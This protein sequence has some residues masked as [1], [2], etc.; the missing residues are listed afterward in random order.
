MKNHNAAVGVFVTVGLIVF[1]VGIF[2]VG[3]R[4]DA[5]ARHV[6]YYAEFTNLNGLTEGSK[7]RVA[8]MDAGQVIEVG[9][10]DNP[11]HRFRIKLRINE[12]LHG[13]IRTDSLASIATEGVVGGTYVLVLPGKAASNPAPPL[14]TLPTK[15]TADISKALDRAIV[16]LSDA[17]ATIN[18]VRGKVS[19]A[20]T[21]VTSTVGNVNQLVLGLKQGHGPAGM[22][23]QDE[24]LASHIRNTVSNTEKATQDLSHAVSQA[25][26]LVADFKG[27]NLPDKVDESVTLV[28]STA[29]NLNE[30]SRTLKNVLASAMEPDKNGVDGA[31]NIRESISNLNMA[32]ANMVDNSEALKHNFLFRGFFKRRGYYNLSSITPSQYRKEKIF[33]NP[34]NRR[35]WIDAGELFE[36][37]EGDEVLSERGKQFL[38]RALAGSPIVSSAGVVM[39][40]GYSD[41][42]TGEGSLVSTR[43]AAQIKIYLIQH[44]GIDRQV[45][46]T[47]S[48]QNT[49]PKGLGKASWD[50]IS[51]VFITSGR[52]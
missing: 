25:D 4:H 43:R 14:Y 51:L 24:R 23:L 20:L 41:R 18:D 27:R 52:E 9:V 12:K 2:L 35:L 29:S 1:G 36:E 10:P 11:A 44:F 17:D 21:S 34:N 28:K 42:E 49:P 7:V 15:E 22:L 45:L 46:G 8:G 38:D 37:V 6:E 47:V 33:T 16:L 40:E 26:S 5:F 19:D 32:S 48:M 3:S 13:L 31:T 30:T 39:I 50:G